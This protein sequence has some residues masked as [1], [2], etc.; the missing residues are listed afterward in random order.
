VKPGF[1][2]FRL[3]VRLESVLRI[4]FG[5]PGS[6]SF[7][8]AW[9]PLALGAAS[10]PPGFELVK[11]A[12]GINRSERRLDEPADLDWLYTGLCERMRRIF[13]DSG[14]K[15]SPAILE[16]FGQLLPSQG[17][18]SGFGGHALPDA[19]K[20]IFG[21]GPDLE[22]VGLSEVLIYEYPFHCRHSHI[23]PL[24]EAGGKTCALRKTPAKLFAAIFSEQ[25]NRIGPAPGAVAHLRQVARGHCAD[26]FDHFLGRLFYILKRRIPVW[27]H[28]HAIEY[29][30]PQTRHCPGDFFDV[31]VVYRR[32]DNSVHLDRNSSAL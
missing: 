19:M 10:S 3:R 16:G 24:A 7:A 21:P 8:R 25:P 27:V 20:T 26:L 2:P 12:A 11:A 9:A 1:T 6:A 17:A 22:P 18:S 14:H 32:N 23:R 30:D 28:R 5:D 31:A 4:S 15:D 13:A 29:I